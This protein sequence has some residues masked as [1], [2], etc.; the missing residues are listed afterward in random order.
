[1]NFKK[2]N[3]CGSG[4]VIPDAVIQDQGE[5]SHGQ[6]RLFIDRK[7]DALIFRDRHYSEVSG[8]LCCECG[9]VQLYCA[10]RLEELWE[11][12]NTRE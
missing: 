6:L 1:M 3:I 4:K 5:H 12:Y 9:N 11:A 8:V 2:C 10:D 7:P